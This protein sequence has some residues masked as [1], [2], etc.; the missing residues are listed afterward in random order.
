MR[1]LRCV[2]LVAIAAGIGCKREP[3]L[4]P[5]GMEP[6]K[7]RA[8]DGKSVWCKSKDGATVQW[9]ELWEG[10]TERRQ[11]CIYRS[12]KI[13]GRFFGWHKGGNH[14]IEGQ[15]RSGEKE[16]LWT[17]WDKDGHKVAEG[18]Y[19]TGQLVGGAPVGMV[20]RCETMKP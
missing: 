9:I 20:A 6:M 3:N 15:Y 2:V 17:Q 13:E 16:G 5:K 8:T 7:D 14:W 10:G 1:A 19:R 12:G 18:E 4:C 11:T